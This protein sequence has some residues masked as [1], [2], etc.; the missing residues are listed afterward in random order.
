MIGQHL[1]TA[2][3]TVAAVVL[4]AAVGA[5]RADPAPPAALRTEVLQSY[6]H[7]PEAFTQGLLLHD[8]ALYE[9]TGLYGHSSLRQVELATGAVGR[10]VDLPPNLFGEGL[11]LAG[12]TL[13]QLTWREGVAP[14]YAL[15]SFARNG[16]FTYG[17][18]GWGLCFDG[19]Q[20]IQS[21]GSHRLTFRD[22]TTFAVTRQ[23]AVTMQGQP[24]TAL[25]EL[26]C[27]GDSVYANIWLTDRIVEIAKLNGIVR[28][29]IDASG[30]LSPTER[31][32]LAREAILNGIAYDAA[33]H[34]FLVTGKL[35]PKLFRV[36]FV[37][38]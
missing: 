25:N 24:V 4:L 11:A 12:G 6:P 19:T 1:R 36:R 34:T 8:G 22:P 23:L 14:T 33:D 38:K 20:F 15:E 16:Q 13:V 5:C 3:A 26:E 28:A 35:W 18:E 21:D 7:D 9:S 31:A 32:G 29:T 17:G 30:L 37:P 2:R 10:R 27:V